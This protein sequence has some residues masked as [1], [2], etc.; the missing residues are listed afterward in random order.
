MANYEALMR[1]L[2]DLKSNHAELALTDIQRIIGRPLPKVARSPSWWSND[3]AVGIS[4]GRSRPWLDADF[5]AELLPGRDRV[6]FVRRGYRVV[7]RNVDTVWL[8]REDLSE[9][10]QAEARRTAEGLIKSIAR[11]TVDACTS[12]GVEFDMDDPVVA[13]DVFGAAIEGLFTSPA[14]TKRRIEKSH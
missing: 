4:N 5:K 8:A 7:W 3:A 10:E 11:A 13:R 2:R 14:L 6:S 1:H 9:E 12:L